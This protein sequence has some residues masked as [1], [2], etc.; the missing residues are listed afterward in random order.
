MPA[1]ITG[2]ADVGQEIERISVSIN[3]DIIRLF[4]EG[5][6][7]SPH[8]AVEELVSNS[9][10]ADARQVH[11]LLPEQ[12]GNG[13]SHLAPLWVIDDGHGMDTDG[14]HQL[15][16][17]AESNKNEIPSTPNGR[18]PIGQFGIGKL[19]AYVLAWKLMHLSRVGNKFLLT[20]MNFRDVAGRRNETA[21]PIQIPLREIDEATA[22]SHLAEIEHRD[23]RAWALMFDEKR[24]SSTWT[25][26]ALSDFKDLYT[27]LSTGRLRW[28]L[29]TGLPLHSNFKMSLNGERVTS[30]KKN[31]EIIDKIDFRENLPGIG[32]VSGTAR[33]HKKQLTTGKSEQ[34]GRSNGFFVRVRGRVINLEDELFGIQQLNHAAWSRFALE[35]DA[36]GLRKHLL[37]SREGVRDSDHIRDF[38]KYL[39]EKFNQCRAAF[40]K[41]NR[42]ENDQLDISLLLSDN[43]S[44]HVTEPLFHSVR[45]TIEVG[46]ESFYIDIPSGIEEE[47]H[48]QWLMDYKNEVTEK[49]FEKTEFGDYGRNAPALRYDPATRKLVVNSAHPFVDKLT[50]GGKH[51]DSATL[52]ASS[53]V[54]IE[55]QLQDQGADRLMI[56]EFLRDRDFILRLMAGD[57]PSTATEVLHLLGVANQ[58]ETALERAVGAAFQ[59]LGF[60]YERKGGTAP[61]PDGVLWAR[62]GRH[63]RGIAD[64]KLVYDAKQTNH[65]SVPA[66]KI[67]SST[68]ED[69]RKQNNANFGFFIAKKY[70]AEE[71]PDSALNRR[72]ISESGCLTLLK[73][74]HLKRLVDLHFRHGITLSELRSLFEAAHIVPQVDKWLE[75]FQSR[76]VE[77][78]EIPLNVLLEGLEE[79]K[80]DPKATP[81]IV[82]VRAKVSELQNFGPE[83]LNARLQA[84]EHIIGSRWIEVEGS[85]EVHLHQTAE[86]ILAEINRNVGSLTDDEIA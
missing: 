28:V 79:E 65:P 73:I 49:P 68:L 55:G 85:G 17:V 26:A 60:K 47:D 21:D 37:S 19:A 57:A 22:R 40:D 78:G 3:S 1:D 70:A 48:P 84:V 7:Q 29:S 72:M 46:T 75:E 50:N 15:W 63:E 66:D 36:D 32:E 76:L 45:S 12:P 8:K 18:E 59:V 58:N 35:A 31:L 52:F 5:L 23:P 43:P 44:S 56:N 77:Q 42:K 13:E 64:Y 83:R 10:D 54:L 24:R 74:S 11:V 4:S 51:R 61:G 69:F 81:N 80:K 16:R 30:S 39:S 86:Q 6:Y 38:R 25:A 9:Y 62:L 27:K 33:V 71:N 34:F 41:W 82:A 20:I 67:N 53:E 14:F 2:L